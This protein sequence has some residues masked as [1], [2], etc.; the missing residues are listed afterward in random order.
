MKLF[1]ID[2]TNTQTQI[3]GTFAK[4]WPKAWTRQFWIDGI[5]NETDG[6]WYYYSYKKTP[7]FENLLWYKGGKGNC[8]AASSTDVP[9][10]VIG[11]NCSGS[12]IPVCEYY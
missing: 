2:S 3:L 7:A 5:K 11:F 1:V 12:V 6:K 4:W 10:K 8:L 9:F